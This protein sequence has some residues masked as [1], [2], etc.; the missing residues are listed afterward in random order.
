MI[1]TVFLDIDGILTDGAVYVDSSGNETKRMIFDDIDAIFELKR[2]NIK[3][4]FL[5][6][7]DGPFCEY[8][9]RRFNPDF[10]LTGCK[11]KLKRFKN[12]V[13][14]ADLDADRI[15]YAGDSKKD[16]DLLKY[17]TLSFAPADVAVEVR[18]SAKVVLKAGRGQ[19]VV[20]E[21]ADRILEKQAHPG[22]Y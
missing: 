1:D 21:L 22:L 11:D 20:R 6:G 12:L 10:F 9:R 16:I 4:G 18:A 7:E 17:L 14:E 2:N 3:I 13:R 15:C 8:I 19:G 5:T